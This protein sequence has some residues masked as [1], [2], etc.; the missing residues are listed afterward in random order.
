[1]GGMCGAGN[2]TPK[3][4]QQLAWIGNSNDD[5]EGKQFLDAIVYS[6]QHILQRRIN[7]C[8]NA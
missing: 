7:N 6:L 5:I 1:M 3:E 2:P 8:S 4:G